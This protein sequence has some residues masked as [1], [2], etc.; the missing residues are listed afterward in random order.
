MEKNDDWIRIE[1]P[2][3]SFDVNSITGEIVLRLNDEYTEFVRL[4]G[5]EQLFELIT[6][7]TDAFVRTYVEITGPFTP[8]VK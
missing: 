7:I 6:K 4:S 1:T 5:K 2:V 3:G 8:K